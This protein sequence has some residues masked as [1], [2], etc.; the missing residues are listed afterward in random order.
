MSRRTSPSCVQPQTHIVPKWGGSKW[1]GLY[2]DFTGR[3]ERSGLILRQ[4]GRCECTWGEAHEPI[5]PSSGR[6]T[7]SFEPRECRQLVGRNCRLVLVAAYRRAGPESGSAAVKSPAQNPVRQLAAVMPHTANTGG[8]LGR[9]A[10][11]E[12]P[13]RRVEHHRATAAFAVVT[14]P[15]VLGIPAA[16]LTAYRNAERLMAQAMPGCG[17]AGTCWPASGASNPCTPTKAPPTPAAPPSTPST[18]RHSTGRCLAT[19]SSSTAAPPTVARSMPVRWAPCSS[20]LAPGCAT[21]PTATATVK[22]TRRISSTPPWPLPTT[23][24]AGG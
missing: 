19:G 11:G 6:H 8:T 12:C 23:C 22:P 17:S 4:R 13:F 24:A 14:S 7:T 20:F 9:L 21:A 1:C 15:G 3:S 2:G 16:A 10:A 18:A 5:R